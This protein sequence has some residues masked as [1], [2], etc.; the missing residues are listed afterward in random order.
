[1]F[2][3]VSLDSGNAIAIA[4]ADAVASAP[5]FNIDLT[6][7]AQRLKAATQLNLL[8]MLSHLPQ[9]LLTA[10]ASVTPTSPGASGK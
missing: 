2:A 7:A 10:P 6:D 1:V 5:T 3:F 9:A 8:P 4:G